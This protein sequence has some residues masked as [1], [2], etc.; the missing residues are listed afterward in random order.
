MTWLL[1]ASAVY[2]DRLRSEEE[3]EG[4]IELSREREASTAD[5]AD[6][7][8]SA[9]CLKVPNFSL[10]STI[11]VRSSVKKGTLHDF[12]KNFLHVSSQENMWE[13]AR[14]KM[15]IFSRVEMLIITKYNH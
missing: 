8:L 3:R 5:Y 14:G 4:E 12:L 15:P 7:M 2:D 9:C 6:K 10:N 13:G 1:V 11:F